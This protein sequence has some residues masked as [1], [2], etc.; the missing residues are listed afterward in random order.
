MF[1]FCTCSCTMQSPLQSKFIATRKIWVLCNPSPLQPVRSEF[2]IIQVHC[3]PWDLSPLQS[4]SIAT[5]KIW[6][7]YNPSPLQPVRSETFA[8]Q[9]HCN[10]W[11]LRPLQSKSI[12][13][14]E[15]WVLYNPSPFIIIYFSMWVCACGSL[16]QFEYHSTLL[17][18]FLSMYDSMDD[19]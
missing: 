13:T 9:V 19:Y 4:K 5:R 11:D 16:R 7:L 6:V 15:I 12:A 10:P 3:N 8:I 18:L 14:R 1:D 2:F 17:Y